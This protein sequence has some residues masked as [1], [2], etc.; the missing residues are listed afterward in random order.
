VGGLVRRVKK[1]EA[2]LVSDD[3]PVCG[4]SPQAP[5]RYEVVWE[6]ANPEDL[7]DDPK[8]PEFCHGCGQQL[9]YIVTWGAL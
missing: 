7:E 8:E 9:T 6:D 1:L 4:Y 2:A 5:I 3:C